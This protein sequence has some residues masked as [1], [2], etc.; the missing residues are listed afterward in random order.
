MRAHPPPHHHEKCRVC[1]R[2]MDPGTLVPAHYYNPKWRRGWVCVE[3]VN[4][5]R[6]KN[7]AR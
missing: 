3:H 1:G 5:G 7:P 2:I 4:E 6:E